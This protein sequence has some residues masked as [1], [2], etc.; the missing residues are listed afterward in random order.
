MGKDNTSEFLYGGV[1]SVFGSLPG[2]YITH[3]LGGRCWD[4]KKKEYIDFISGYGSLSLGHC[5]PE[6][7]RAVTEQLER[8]MMFPSNS[9]LHSKLVL[10]LKQIFPYADHSLFLKT[11][12][13]AVSAAIRLARAFTGKNK[14]IR[15]GFA[16]WH[17]SVISPIVSWHLY[18]QDSQT[19]RVAMGIPK[20]N[21]EPL[22]LPWDG[23]NFQQLKSLLRTYHGDIAALIL[24]PVQMREPFENYLKKVEKLVHDEGGLF[25]LDETK[26]GFR[27]SLS[28]VQGIYKTQ[29]DLTILGKGMSNGFPLSVVIGR[30]EI[31]DLFV[32]A[33][34]MGTFNS[35]LVSITAA[36]KTISILRKP[37][38]IPH[39]WKIGERLIDGINVILN[40]YGLHDDIQAVAYRWPCMPFIWFHNNSNRA[41]VL[42]PMF[43]R[44]LIRSGILFLSNHMSFICLAHTAHDVDRTLQIMNDVWKDCLSGK[45]KN[46]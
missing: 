5:N 45:S 14:I 35:E 15:C 6:V 4:Q 23:E 10:T 24:D 44:Q 18:E 32:D 28:G 13:E 20:T 11:G 1:S 19:P 17:D 16:G 33:K 25:I 8:G 42:K 30:K 34:I 12:S 2:T 22:V 40:Q 9:P 3:G 38:T 37:A 7:N 39:L 36:L 27:V 26:T 43:Y 29:P 31:I 46:T 21:S 41:Q